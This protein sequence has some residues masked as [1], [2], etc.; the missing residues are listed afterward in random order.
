MTDIVPMLLGEPT[1]LET[2]LLE[3][4]NDD[5]PGAE[6][7]EKVSAALGVGA[8]ALAAASAGSALAGQAAAAGN[9]VALAKPLTVVSLAKWLAVGIGAGI[10]T[11]GVAQVASRA[12]EPTPS[13]I[14]TAAPVAAPRNTAAAHAPARRVEV[15]NPADPAAE[16]APEIAAAPPSSTGTFAPLP[17]APAVA[18]A[19]PTAA[20]VHTGSAAFEAPAANTVGAAAA[21]TLSD[22]TKALDGARAALTRGRAAEA[23]AGLDAYRA[24]WP[25]GAL[26]AEAALLRVDALL[27]LGN[28]PAAE[29]EANALISAAPSSRYAT[30]A[31]TLLAAKR[32]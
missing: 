16:P 11:G 5:E 15:A 2:L 29:R 25:A 1:E 30:R 32:E 3:S 20:P 7:L 24:K 27:R 8:A 4:A 9:V 19:P 6:A 31:R 18:D 21:S 10:A 14:V 22:E 13:A 26:R 28:R 23:L 12:V 17:A